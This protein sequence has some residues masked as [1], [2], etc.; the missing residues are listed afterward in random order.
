MS[1]KKISFVIPC[2]CSEKSISYVVQGIIETI[3][4]QSIY[5]YEIILINDASPDNTFNVI[6]EL[7]LENKKVKCINFSKNFGQH[8]ALMAGYSIVS[9]DIVV[10]LDDDGEHDPRDM[11]KLIERLEEGYDYVCAKHPIKNH[12]F[13]QNLGSKINNL[14]ATV[15]IDKPKEINFSSYYA[16]KRFVIDEIIKYKNPYPYIGGLILGITKNFSEVTIEHHKR[17]YG[18]SGYSFKKMLNLWLNGFTAFSVKP[19]RIAAILGM[20]CSGIGFIYGILIIIIKLFINQDSPMGY[21]SI[22]AAIM[23]MGGMIM[24]MLGIIGEYVGRIYISINNIPQYVI[25]EKIDYEKQNEYENLT[26]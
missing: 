2:Y 8:S 23:F 6:K 18:S 13:I 5:D 22:M 1:T 17:L 24:L 15:L 4:S 3:E 26:M 16:M 7:A 12:S 19:L 9:G 10:G 25:K 14:M 11:F 20:I 21:S